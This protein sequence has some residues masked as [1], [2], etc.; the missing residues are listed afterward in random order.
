MHNDMMIILMDASSVV[1]HGQATEGHMFTAAARTCNTF[2]LCSLFRWK[3]RLAT[4]CAV[5]AQLSYVWMY[6]TIVVG[7]AYGMHRSGE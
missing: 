2:R 4:L 1:F 3:L 6:C 7:H 5:T